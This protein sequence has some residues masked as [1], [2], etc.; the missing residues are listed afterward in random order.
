MSRVL[1][2]VSEGVAASAE[3]TFEVLTD[4]DRHGEWMP[5]T[6]ARGGH[7]VGATLEGRTGAGPIGFLDTMIITEWRDGRRVAV[8]H[9][10]RLVRGEAWFET[11]P[12]PEGGCVVVWAEHLDLPLGPL[13]RVGWVVIGPIAR[14]FMRLGLRRLGRLAA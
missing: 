12:L 9:T 13:G 11:T 1:A 4:W 2:R 14:A 3:R 5:F 6:T 10:G 7:E 8:R